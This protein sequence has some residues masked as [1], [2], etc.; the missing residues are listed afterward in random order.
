MMIEWLGK[1]LASLGLASTILFT[2]L[3]GGYYSMVERVSGESMQP[4]SG[5]T[6]MV[7]VLLVLLW[8]WH[9]VNYGETTFSS[10][11]GLAILTTYWMAVNILI[12]LVVGW[13]YGV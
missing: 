2:V 10:L 12:V 13:L 4:L 11:N 9:R 6:T 1:N 3:G 5:L 8:L 7:N